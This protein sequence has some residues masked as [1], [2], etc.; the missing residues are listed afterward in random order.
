[1][2]IG[3]FFVIFAP[4]YHKI[5][6]KENNRVRDFI[7]DEFLTNKAEPDALAGV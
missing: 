3:C 2:I 1:V 7:K 5:L 4:F 6:T